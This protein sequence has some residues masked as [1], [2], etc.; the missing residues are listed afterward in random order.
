GEGHLHIDGLRDFAQVFINGKR[1]GTLN[2]M[3]NQ[4]EL[5]LK[6]PAGATL[7][8]LVENLGR[9]NYGRKM[10][11]NRK[12]II[13]KVSFNNKRLTGWKMYSL[14][15]K[16]ANW[17]KFNNNTGNLKTPVV[18]KGTFYLNKTG[19]TFLDMRK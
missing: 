13:G 10:M 1:V 6:A 19:D 7:D 12:G 5:D 8:I 18:Y 9:I 2:R 15:F 3:Y 11:K 4:K 16:N 17:L 14:P